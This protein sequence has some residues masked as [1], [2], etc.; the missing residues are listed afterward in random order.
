MNDADYLRATA[1][2]ARDVY[3][4]TPEGREFAERLEAIAAKLE[5]LE[6]KI[7]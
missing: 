6:P 7:D 1:K 3:G 2:H 5:S 4:V